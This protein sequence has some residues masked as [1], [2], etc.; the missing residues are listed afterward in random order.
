MYVQLNSRQNIILQMKIVLL[1]L[2]NNKALYVQIL[3][4]KKY[5]TKFDSIRQFKIDYN[6]KPGVCRFYRDALRT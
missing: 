5:K 2:Y 4:A 3:T 6:E 1:K